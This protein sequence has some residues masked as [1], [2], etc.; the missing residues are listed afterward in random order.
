MRYIFTFLFFAIT[1]CSSGQSFLDA[2]KT[3]KTNEIKQSKTLDSLRKTELNKTID[4]TKKQIR[5]VK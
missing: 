3:Y 2:Y 1:F 4:L 5:N